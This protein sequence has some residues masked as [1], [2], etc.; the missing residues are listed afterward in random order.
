[1]SKAGI[2]SCPSKH[3]FPVGH[4]SWIQSLRNILVDLKIIVPFCLFLGE[5]L[6]IETTDP[7]TR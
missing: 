7:R 2:T 4:A 6:D 1:M 5:L 3:V